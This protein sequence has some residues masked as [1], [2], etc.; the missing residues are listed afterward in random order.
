MVEITATVQVNYWRPLWRPWAIVR[1]Y[2][3]LRR[4]CQ[5]EH[6]FILLVGAWIVASTRVTSYS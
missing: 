4:R 3:H 1:G 6:W 5:H 2:K